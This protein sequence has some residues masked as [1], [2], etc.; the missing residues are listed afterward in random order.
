MNIQIFCDQK[1]CRFNA[2]SR[3]HHDHSTDRCE[4]PFPKIYKYGQPYFTVGDCKCMSKERNMTNPLTT[5]DLQ[6]ID[7][8]NEERVDPI[9]TDDKN[10]I[11]KQSLSPLPWWCSL[12]E[13]WLYV[14]TTQEVDDHVKTHH[15]YEKKN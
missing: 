2:G 7:K 15:P 14:N 4:H 5:K 11:R 10:I 6:D 1:D 12:C 8:A 13:K 3:V 9:D